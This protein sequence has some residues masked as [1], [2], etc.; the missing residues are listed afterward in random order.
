MGPRRSPASWAAY[1]A[2]APRA[3]REPKQEQI[4]QARQML[5]GTTSRA[6]SGAKGNCED[7][8]CAIT[9]A[10]KAEKANHNPNPRHRVTHA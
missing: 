1:R 2:L 5:S 4:E 3:D 6:K 10:D 8:P 7:G 9:G